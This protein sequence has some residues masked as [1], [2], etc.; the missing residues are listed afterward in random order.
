[1]RTRTAV[2]SAHRRRPLPTAHTD[3]AIRA[4]LED[5]R[6]VAVLGA[7][8]KPYR[9]G[10]YVPDY[11]HEQGYGV[12]GVS[13][14]LDGQAIFG[15]VAVGSLGDLEGAF[16]VLDVFRR[17][18]ELPGHEAE[19]LAMQPPPRV[20]WLQLGVRDDAFAERLRARGIVV[21]QDRCMLAEHRRLGV[22][23]RP[24]DASTE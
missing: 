13:P 1:M 23:P 18:E 5:A 7:S 12:V 6:T 9:A 24:R 21:V 10:C 3:E 2:R 14:K 11:L 17:S 8:D 15:S 20:V 22:R 16:D 19:I 4:I